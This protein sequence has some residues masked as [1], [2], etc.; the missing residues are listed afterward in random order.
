MK[1]EKRFNWYR[2]SVVFGGCGEGTCV[3]LCVYTC[4]HVG[5]VA[6][7]DDVCKATNS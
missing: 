6:D 4:E 5:G 1:Y 7:G 3:F 2:E